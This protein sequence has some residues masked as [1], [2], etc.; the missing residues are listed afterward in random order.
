M[1]CHT[2]VQIDA[3]RN[4]NDA[5]VAD[6]LTDLLLSWAEIADAP[7]TRVVKVS[8]TVETLPD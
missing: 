1:A 4:L 5:A 8:I 6:R 3:N 7:S 2:E